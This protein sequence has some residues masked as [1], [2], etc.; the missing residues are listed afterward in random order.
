MIVDTL[1][2]ALCDDDRIFRS[3]LRAEVERSFSRFAD[4]EVD[5]EEVDQANA[6]IDLVG[7]KHIDVVFLD[8]DMPDMDGI[9][10]GELLRGKGAGCEIVY[11]SN[12]EDRVYD[13]FRVHPWSFIRKNHCTE[14]I[15]A[16]VE[17]YVKARHAGREQLLLPS[18]SGATVSVRPREVIYAEAAGKLQKVFLT[19]REKELLVRVSLREL[20]QMLASHGFI[21]V[22]K[23]F[24]V[25]YL[26][27]RK[28]TSR[29]VVL[30]SGITLPIGRD[31]LNPAREQYLS[32]MKWKGIGRSP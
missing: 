15:D 26:F 2:I 8:I 3:S 4:L 1:R 19:G 14:E 18:E 5:T 7:Q 31:R 32:L 29:N 22:H 24:L 16:V 9:Q 13:V 30:D 20:E 11:V 12:M 28:I 23:G 10:C 27:I 6:L 25:N 21:R 17:G